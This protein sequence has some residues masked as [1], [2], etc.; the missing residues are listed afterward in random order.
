MVTNGG[1]VTNEDGETVNN[2]DI[3]ASINLLPTVK[4]LLNS[5]E[6]YKLTVEELEKN[7]KIKNKYSYTD[8]RSAVSISSSADEAL[9]VDISFELTSKEDVATITNTFLDISSDF[10]AYKIPGSIAEPVDYADNTVKTAPATAS[11]TIL[12]ALVGAFVCYAVA[13]LIFTFNL[14]IK[15]EED[16]SSNYDIPVI[17]NIPDFSSNSN[18]KA[19]SKKAKRR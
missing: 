8:L 13:F 4:G 11:T 17:G 2:S 12:A 16:F 5:K 18:T 14:T 3:A 1:I 6:V 9:L 10:I 19:T 7:P 15:S